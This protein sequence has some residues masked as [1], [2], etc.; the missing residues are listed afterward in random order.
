MIQTTGMFYITNL[1]NVST[2]DTMTTIGLDIPFDVQDYTDIKP[3]L[4][5]N[6]S[7]H[8]QY[9][10]SV[11]WPSTFVFL[12][13][14][15]SY[16]LVTPGQGM[17][18]L[19]ELTRKC[20][21]TT[22]F[23]SFGYKMD[24]N[25]VDAL[26]NTNGRL[27]NYINMITLTNFKKTFISGKTLSIIFHLVGK[28]MLNMDVGVYFKLNL[29]ADTT[30][31]TISLI[32]K[33][34]TTDELLNDLNASCTLLISE[35]EFLTENF[36]TLVKTTAVY[37][38]TSILTESILMD[39][40]NNIRF[41]TSNVRSEMSSITLPVLWT[42]MK[43]SYRDIKHRIA[44]IQLYNTKH[45][46]DTNLMCR[47]GINTSITTL[48]TNVSNVVAKMKIFVDTVLGNNIQTPLNLEL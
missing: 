18:S 41:D 5:Y 14:P 44:E 1:L 32:S 40:D 46:P 22:F 48:N 36:H 42:N 17:M 8:N 2:N 7:V 39:N 28:D 3:P 37:Y 9:V 26:W 38:N 15:F 19:Y 12:N 13:T 33:F 11:K 43:T 47:D 6:M 29:I 4:Y 24:N 23:N 30:I 25:K 10:F 35:I 34:S 31:N 45:T 20:I 27:F 21:S 16:C